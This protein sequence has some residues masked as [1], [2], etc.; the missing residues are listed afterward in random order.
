MLK[1]WWFL[2]DVFRWICIVVVL[3]VFSWNWNTRFWPLRWIRKVPVVSLKCVELYF[4]KSL[5]VFPSIGIPNHYQIIHYLFWCKDLCTRYFLQ[6]S[7]LSEIFSTRITFV[8][9]LSFMDWH[10]QVIFL[11]LIEIRNQYF[12][13]L[14][15]TLRSFTSIFWF[16]VFWAE[17]IFLGQFHDIHDF[18]CILFLFV[19]HKHSTM[20][21]VM[22]FKHRAKLSSKLLNFKKQSEVLGEGFSAIITLTYLAGYFDHLILLTFHEIN[23][24]L[25]H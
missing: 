1:T 10:C 8:I 22:N 23:L 6:F 4:A 11:V 3:L 17:K 16:Y 12:V 5:K 24:K 20:F 18:F 15:S 25:V 13:N 9:S 2:V 14:G 19:S 7:W 21:D